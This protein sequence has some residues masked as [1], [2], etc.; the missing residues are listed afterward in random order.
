M[1]INRY[2]SGVFKNQFEYKSFSPENINHD[3]LLNDAKISNLLSKADRKLGELNAFS[4]LIP[5]VDFYIKMHITKEAT[6]SSKIEGTQTSIEEALQNAE[7]INPEK[8]DDWQEVHN[9]INAMNY[10]I[11]QLDKLPLSNRLLKKTHKKLL[12]GVRGKHKLPGEFRRSQNWIG[13]SSLKDAGFIPP[14]HNEINDLMSD[15][16]KFMNNENLQVP[17]L[18]RIAIA[19]YQFETIH[20]FL[21]GNGRLGRLLI[22]LYLVS[23]QILN[24]PVLYLSDFFESNR[25]SYY[26][27]LTDVRK[28]GNLKQW[29]VFFLVGV[30]ETAQNSIDT[31]N[32]IIKLRQIVEEKKIIT[33]GKRVPL[34]KK[35]IA[36]LYSKP[37][38]E[39]YEIA[40]VLDVNIATAYRLIQDLEK[41]K[42]LK[43]QTGYKR[44][45]VFMFEEYLNI[46]R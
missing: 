2:K 5:D 6:Q 24:K 16:E 4:L 38:V 39:A 41:L 35:L 37:I 13:G 11:N 17:H 45:R 19:H 28:R 1:D 20:P 21:D 30:S 15:L 10:A 18:I 12:Q 40:S 7:S 31:F 22:T 25:E 23:N 8:K 33:L 43:E 29:L 42:I 44:N 3:W 46:Y 32:S 36:Y 14:H 27:N 34:A 26:N 9:Y